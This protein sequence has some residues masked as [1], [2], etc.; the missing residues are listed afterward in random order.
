[1]VSVSSSSLLFSFFSGHG[2]WPTGQGQWAKLTDFVLWCC[3]W[4]KL[5]L[6]VSIQWWSWCVHY[7]ASVFLWQKCCSEACLVASFS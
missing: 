6:V 2:L 4:C 5:V 3:Y 1:M 7:S